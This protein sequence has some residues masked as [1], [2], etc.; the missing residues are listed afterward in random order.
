[1]TTEVKFMYRA[2]VNGDHV[3]VTKYALTK[4]EKTFVYTTADC[5]AGM[6]DEQKAQAGDL[7]TPIRQSDGAEFSS[8]AKAAANQGL[9]PTEKQAVFALLRN[10]N[11]QRKELRAEVKT[12]DAQRATVRAFRKEM[13]EE[14]IA[15]NA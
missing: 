1:M 4:I 8:F 5:F 12:I 10:L 7:W 14:V 2:S 15:P 9:E 3:S 13:L 6:T 11:D